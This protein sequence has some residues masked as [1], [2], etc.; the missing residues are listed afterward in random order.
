MEVSA[1]E[2]RVEQQIPSVDAG[3]LP[4]FELEGIALHPKSL[5]W[6]P[7][8]EIEHP[9]IIKMEG[10]VANP[11]GKYYLY[12]AP[13][14]HVGVGLAYSDNIAGPWK[15]YE[16]NPVVKGPAAPDIRWIADKKKFYLWGH[17]NNSRTELWTSDDGIHF[18]H[19]G[20]SISASE[21][22]TKNATYTRFYEYPIEK[23]GSRYIMLYSGFFKEQ[24]VR[25]VWLAHSKDGRQWT[26]LKS[27][28]VKPVEGEN[29]QLYCPALF[30]WK[31]R[32]FVVYADCTSWRGGRLRYVELDDELNPVG[33]GGARHTLLEAPADLANRLRS[34]EF[35][36]E[37]DTVHMIAGGGKGPR[38]VV[39]GTASLRRPGKEKKVE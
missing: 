10:L 12:Y 9:A 14:K 5:S 3:P 22:G 6:I 28:L 30:R 1:R 2:W 25:C 36:V 26:Q 20:V 17:T 29:K 31:G 24:G 7:T 21:I 23:Y 37:G 35:V 8:G 32:N 39:Y 27:P 33:D 4:E 34:P 13:H 16:G 38:V 15:E 18:E 11:L 19:D